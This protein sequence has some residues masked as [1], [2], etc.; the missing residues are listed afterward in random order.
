MQ[1][2]NAACLG[3]GR[4]RV[5]G[6]SLAEFSLVL[7]VL[8]LIVFG[9]I[10]FGR[11][12]AIYSMVSSASRN[13]TRYGAAVGNSGA[14]VPYYLDCAGIRAEAKR[15]AAA[16]LNLS[17]SDISIQ[18]DNGQTVYGAFNCNPG[19]TAPN[20]GNI[21]SGDRLRVT[22]TGT[23]TP[24]VPIVQIPPLPFTF[25][26]TR[27][28]IKTIA[29]P[30]ECNDGTDNDDDGY[31]D[32]PSDD[33]C[34][35]IDD[36]T[37]ATTN[38]VS[39]ACSNGIEDEL[40]GDGLID[41]PADPGCSSASDSTESSLSI[42]F[43]A[44]YPLKQ[45]GSKPVRIKV[46]VTDENGNGVDDAVVTVVLPGS[47][48]VPLTSLGDGEYGGSATPCYQTTSVS[49]NG[50]TVQVQAVKGADTATTPATATGTNS[51]LCP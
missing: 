51:D 39:A 6:Q 49:G 38:V 34:Q 15:G 3:R 21:A 47:Q 17:D 31:T 30:P 46:S 19:G 45:N 16:L 42:S 7:P 35:S 25:V 28:I 12:M 11:L 5:K 43:I 36:N 26:S 4:I 8:L 14:G 1:T 44:P 18:Y 41:Y 2:V 24:L 32:F 9:V 27:T 23:Y 20:A 48:V 37:E 50:T 29:G 40:P 22:V 10:E 13:A 33:G